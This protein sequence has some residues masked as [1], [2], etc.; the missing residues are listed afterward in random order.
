MQHS[1]G[2]SKHSRLHPGLRALTPSRTLTKECI[3][4]SGGLSDSRCTAY[5][6]AAPPGFQQLA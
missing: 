6:Y 3:R 5:M 2:R 4:T 1:V